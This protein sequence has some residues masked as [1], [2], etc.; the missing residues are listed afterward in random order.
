MKRMI[1]TPHQLP[2]SIKQTPRL[3]TRY[4]GGV[5]VRYTSGGRP[6]VANAEMTGNAE[7]GE[8]IKW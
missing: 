7:D 1:R 6:A 2:G 5:K 3:L 8:L 4:S